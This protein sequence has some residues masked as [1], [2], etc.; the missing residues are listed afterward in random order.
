MGGLPT[1]R[2]IATRRGGAVFVVGLLAISALAGPLA[3]RWLVART[4]LV[5][6]AEPP[7]KP[8]ELRWSKAGEGSSH[9]ALIRGSG[10]IA[11]PNYEFERPSLV[12]PPEEIL[13]VRRLELLTR[14]AGIRLRRVPLCPVGG[15][16]TGARLVGT[17]A[18]VAL[19]APRG[20]RAISL[21]V[22]ALL[23]VGVAGSG[24]TLW[25]LSSHRGLARWRRR[26][27]S[28][29]LAIA[30]VLGAQL[31]LLSY[32]P[33]IM[34]GDSP[35]YAVNSALFV[36]TGSLT[37]LSPYRTPGYPLFLAPFI[38]CAD[39]Y[40]TAVGVAQAV[41]TLLTALL[42]YLMLRRLAPRPAPAAGALLVGLDPALLTL[43]R[44]VLSET[45]STF[46]VALTGWLTMK[47]VAPS[48]STSRAALTALGAGAAAA[49][50]AYG[51][52]NLLVLVF[53]VPVFVALSWAL[54]RRPRAGVKMGA[55]AAVAAAV[56]V[57]PWLVR[58]YVE[59][60]Q[61][62]F[63]S[64]AAFAKAIT[65]WNN[66]V[67]EPNQSRVFS[68]EE[69]EAV[70]RGW[71]T[72]S[73]NDFGFLRALYDASLLADQ[74]LEPNAKSQRV[75]EE[76]MSRHPYRVVG[77]MLWALAA[78]LNIWTATEYSEQAWLSLPLRGREVPFTTNI[79][80]STSTLG[81]LDQA[82]L[83]AML[84]RSREEIGHLRQSI[85][86]RRFDNL[87]EVFRGL[88]PLLFILFLAGCYFALRDRNLPLLA[89]AALFAV[90]ALAL[91]MLLM[92][93]IDRYPLPFKAIVATVAVYGASRLCGRVGYPSRS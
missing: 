5:D 47:A 68:P 85:S 82:Q 6:L 37:T 83:E 73:M 25:Y 43:Q 18:G 35:D 38:A 64:G 46:F 40:A 39:R 66:G 53:L 29:H 20:D 56:L 69:V 2:G 27:R 42:T 58:N 71:Q 75:V 52:G 3:H 91:S 65:A 76:S 7:A 32:A 50:A 8:W 4:V 70:E 79:T 10:R 14:V 55:C 33:M 72:G 89:I 86:A 17:G 1:L 28:E 12:G 90:H 60:E 15:A 19:Q 61:F 77:A 31:W 22:L 45:L 51:R 24:L 30:G 74:G 21:L 59:H 23:G 16:C 62:T 11:F 63:Q 34:A 67:I 49:A 13:D 54:Q 48:S 9:G 78:Q 44:Y 88:R 93:V 26:I 87:Y 36:E 92:A 41:L 57:L 80:F 84:E 81:W